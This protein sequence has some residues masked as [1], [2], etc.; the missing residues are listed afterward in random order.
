MTGGTLARCR[1][2]ANTSGQPGGGV[3]MEGGGYLENCLIL[4]NIPSGNNNGGGVWM[5]NVACRV[6]QSTISGNQ[7]SGTGDGGGIFR[8]AGGVVTNSIIYFNTKAG[9]AASDV[10]TGGSEASFRFC[11]ASDLI[12]DPTGTGNITG[13]PFFKNPSGGDYTLGIGSP[14]IDTGTNLAD[15]VSDLDGAFRPTDGSG[16]GTPRNDIGAYEAPDP[17]AGPLAINFSADVQSAPLSLAVAF[18]ALPSGSDTNN[19]YYGWDYNNDGV[20]DDE[21][22]GLG[23]PTHLYSQPGLYSVSLTVSNASHEIATEIKADYIRVYAAETFVSTNGAN[24]LP[25]TNWVTAAS[26][27]QDAVDAVMSGGWVSVGEGVYRLSNEVAVLRGITVRGDGGRSNTVIERLTGYTTRLFNLADSNAVLDELTIRNGS[28]PVADDNGGGVYL[29]AG[30]IQNCIITNC[31]AIYGAGL[32]Q[33]GGWVSNTLFVKNPTK[34]GG[35]GSGQ[36]G[37]VFL[38]GGEVRGC[39]FRENSSTRQGA[40]VRMAGVATLTHCIIEHNTDAYGGSVNVSAN[41]LIDNCLII[42]N[43]GGSFLGG[44]GIYLASAG[45][46]VLNCTVV[47]NSTTGNGGGIQRASGGVT[48][49][50]VFGNFA[51][52]SG[53][54]ISGAGGFGYSCSP[55]LTHDPDG[56]G[57]INLS[58]QF[59]LMGTG[60]GLSHLPGNYRLDAFSPC[61][62]SGFSIPEW[63]GD[64]DLDGKRRILAGRIDMGCYESLPSAGTL[65]LFY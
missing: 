21:G 46:S 2:T 41:G 58:P 16:G 27:I 48:N 47:G 17:G 45:A 40:A 50:I 24:I 20:D 30:T 60:Y 13:D 31:T 6:V 28:A 64:E 39:T 15:V 37:G 65:L 26:N 54:D 56:S 38:T 29:S 61:A 51:A 4:G 1:V 8:S 42:G 53:Q 23:A 36:G 5:N 14:C 49:T 12:N 19:L 9:G 11:C 18:T 22:Y 55:D 57:N 10:V 52:G 34:P 33:T 62:N 7:V 43:S 35:G 25:Y 44:G 3:A 32:Y 63:V 59:I